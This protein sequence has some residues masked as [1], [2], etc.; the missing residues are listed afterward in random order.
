MAI[1]K[2]FSVV[3]LVLVF[4]LGRSAAQAQIKERK[5]EVS[6][7]Y[8]T[9]NLRAF[10]SRESGAGVR[11][12]YNLNNYLA[13]EAEGN[14]FDFRI[15]D[16]PT[17]DK[18]AAQGLVGIKTGLR[19]RW[20]GVFAKLRPGVVNFPELKVR[21]S[22]CSLQPICE[23]SGRSGNR[24]AVDAGAVVELYPTRNIIVRVD[25]GDTMIRFRDDID[26]GFL[27]PVKIKDGFSHN[28][29]WTGSVG[30]RF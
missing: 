20:A 17:N 4:A 1:K 24:L 15:G 28:F 11:L 7:L 18:L 25:V 27:P 3:A 22:F 8:T 2:A 5:F 26:Y 14:L 9:I 10:D 19:N 12:A 23:R 21:R 6:P 13:V 16:H 30:F 29:Q